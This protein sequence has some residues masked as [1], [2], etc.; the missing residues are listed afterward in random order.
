MYTPDVSAVVAWL[1]ADLN[2][3]S[4]GKRTQRPD[5]VLHQSSKPNACRTDMETNGGQR[6]GGGTGAS[7]STKGK[8]TKQ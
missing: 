2:C 3:A 7:L 4:S 5:R 8:I 1:R 6:A